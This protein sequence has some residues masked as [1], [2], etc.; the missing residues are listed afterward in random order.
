MK[1]S[2]SEKIRNSIEIYKTNWI[3]MQTTNCYAYALGLDIPER[4]ICRHAYQPG[5]MSGFN[6]LENDFFSY[7]DLIKGLKNDLNY[8]RISA[9]EIDPLES[10][11]LDEWKIALFVPLSIYCPP[12]LLADYHFIKCFPNNTWYHKYGYTSNISNLD[13]KSNVITNPESC[14][15]DGFVYDKTLSL[16]LKK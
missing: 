13:D 5:V 16:R 4:Q 11:D 2:S 14:T 1:E 9:R 15:I 3:N 10:V 7:K 8:L 6:E 12:Y